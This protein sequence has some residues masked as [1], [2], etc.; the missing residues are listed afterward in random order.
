[1]VCGSD[2]L[3]SWDRGPG[4]SCRND[5]GYQWYGRAVGDASVSRDGSPDAS[6]RNGGRRVAGV[7]HYFCGMLS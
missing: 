2:A 7:M 1:M 5:G 3:V 6:R 4:A